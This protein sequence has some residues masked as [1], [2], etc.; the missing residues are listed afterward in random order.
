MKCP[1]RPLELKPKAIGLREMCVEPEVHYSNSCVGVTSIK[2][3]GLNDVDVRNGNRISSR[4]EACIA[5]QRRIPTAALP[6]TDLGPVIRL[7]TRRRIS[8]CSAGTL[9]RWLEN[10][11][12][13]GHQSHQGNASASHS[14][15]LLYSRFSKYAHKK[16]KT[17]KLGPIAL[18][19][20]PED[21]TFRSLQ[22]ATM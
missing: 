2:M 15:Y 16:S 12:D 17:L 21:H 7:P 4:V 6:A 5:A 14:L 10:G 20:G 8:N 22:L 9:R 18:M 13:G 19:R 1:G 3:A 11:S